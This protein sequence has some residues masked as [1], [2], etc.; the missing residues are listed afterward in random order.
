[1]HK[2][3]KKRLFQK[4]RLYYYYFLKFF[5]L[6]SLFKK[7]YI[8]LYKESKK[9]IFSILLHIYIIRIHF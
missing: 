2:N 6:L 7:I 1:M 8:Y 4:I 3:K 5:I 9:L